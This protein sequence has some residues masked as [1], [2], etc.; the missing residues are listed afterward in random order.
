MENLDN[1]L[2][3]QQHIRNFSIVAH[4]DHGK[5]TIADRI[6]EKTHTVEARNMHGQMLDT[7]ELE[8]ERGITIKLNSVELTYTAQN[9]E[10]YIFHLIDTPGHV[11]FTYEVS[12]SLAAAEGA[13]LVVDASQGVEAQT[14][15]NAYLAIDNDLEILPVINKIDLPSA[16]PQMAAE[17]IEDVIG[18]PTDNAVFMSAK[19]GVGVDDLLEKIVTELPAPTGDLK[20]PLQALIFDSAYDSYRG[21]VVNIRIRQGM[22]K[23]GDKIKMMNS[24][25]VFEVTEVGVFSPEATKRDFLMAGDVGYLTASI[26]DIQTARSGETITS[27]TN[28]AEAPLPGYKPMNPTVY[29]GMYPVDNAKFEDLREA[30]EKLQLNDASLVFEPETST[31]LGFGFRV[32][33][34]GMLHMDVIQERLEREFDI[35]LVTTAPSVTYKVIL[36]DGEELNVSNPSDMPEASK[37][38][39][40]QEPYVNANLLVPNEYVGAVMELA[41]RKRGEFVT[42]DYLD[43]TRVSVKYQIPLS[44]IIFDFFDKL[45]SSTKGYASIDYEIS[46]YK[47]SA[48]VKIDILLNGDKID[49]LSFIVHKDFAQ[50]RGRVITAKLKE[51]IPRQNFEIPVQAA[52]GNKILARTNIKAYRKDVTARI[53]TGDPDR[54]AKLLDKQKRGKERMKSVGTVSVP[55]EA[56]M[57]VLRTDEDE[58]YKRG[59]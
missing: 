20:A 37:I 48:L 17:E 52:I 25:A 58:E 9:G 54:R 57:A 55:Q 30:L 47:P 32:G 10:D 24:G 11:D 33:F 18:V 27:A 29:A 15:A 51:I 6:L 43:Q 16:D 7:M 50:E 12:R 19:T 14:L 44:E 42:M 8:Q 53:H 26:K 31:A 41:Q 4:I 21:V 23:K 40:I 38:S 34:L 56:F 36:A 45:K 59:N 28:P 2:K 3:R 46:G 39:E 13:L 1:L 35:D 49:A 22:V 5:S